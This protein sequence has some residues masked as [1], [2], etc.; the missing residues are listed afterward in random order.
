MGLIHCVCSC[1]SVSLSYPLPPTVS[2]S[3]RISSA[4]LASNM[5]LY[6]NWYFWFL[7]SLH[8][9]FRSSQ[10]AHFSK[11]KRK[12]HDHSFVNLNL[13]GSLLFIPVSAKMR[14]RVWSA[15]EPWHLH[16]L[17]GTG[18]VIDLILS[19][20]TT[21]WPRMPTFKIS[22]TKIYLLPL[23]CDIHRSN[24]GGWS[25]LGPDFPVKQS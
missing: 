8:Y 6:V 18:H 14:S 17:E 23:L 16:S 12:K 21:T 15:A 9:L 5:C 22:F 10:R 7:L 1:L 3:V 20:I 24:L 13:G 4:K 25:V 11:Y 2:K 19:P